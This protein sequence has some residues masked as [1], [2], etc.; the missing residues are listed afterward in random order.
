MLTQISLLNPEHAS[1]QQNYDLTVRSLDAF[2]T[3]LLGKGSGKPSLNPVLVN[4]AEK[5]SR[6][7]SRV[8]DRILA[9]TAEL[10]ED[11]S[12][13]I[14]KLGMTI[15]GK[16][17]IERYFEMIES[18]ARSLSQMY[19][20]SEI[21]LRSLH[22]AISFAAGSYSLLNAFRGF[23]LVVNIHGDLRATLPLL[24]FGT[25]LNSYWVDSLYTSVYRSINP[26]TDQKLSSWFRQ[27]QQLLSDASP[28]QW[29][30]FGENYILSPPIY[31]ALTT[32]KF[33]TEGDVENQR[34]FDRD[35]V[36]GVLVVPAYRKLRRFPTVEKVHVYFDYLLNTGDGRPENYSLYITMKAYPGPPKFKPKKPQPKTSSEWSPS[37]Q[38]D[39][40]TVTN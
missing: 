40:S 9:Q 33:L 13:D 37:F 1:A 19:R 34:G 27:S 36:R 5:G 29:I 17:S 2:K 31:D 39:M 18:S 32:R 20:E 26:E 35:R 24:V 6:A 10:Q 3:H 15:Q 12:T 38:G 30:Y 23:D 16:D 21:P 7:A 14:A 22:D 11:G 28:H 4:S 8:S 25:V